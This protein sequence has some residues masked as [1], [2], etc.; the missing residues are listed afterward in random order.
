M[1]LDRVKEEI[2]LSI[3]ARYPIIYLISWEE[4]RV[5]KALLDIARTLKKQIY[6]WSCS[7][8]FEGKLQASGAKVTEPLAALD[9]VASST[10]RAIFV[11][12]DFHPFLENFRVVRKL[13]DSVYILRKSYKTLILLSPVLK[14][15]RELEKDIIVYDVPLPDK[16]ELGLILLKF[17]KEVSSSP[18]VTVRSDTELV[19]RFIN[20]ALG[21]TE[22]EAESVFA[23][24]LVRDRK[25]TMDDLPLIIE[26]KKQIIRKSGFL[27]YF[28]LSET[29]ESVGGLADLKRWLVSRAHAFSEKA[30]EYGLPQPKGLLLLGVQGCGKSL[31][32]KA[33][34]SLWKL[35]LIRL[36]VGSVFN[37]F[38]GASEENMRR[39]IKI[40]ESLAPTVL[41]LDEVEKGFGTRLV[42]VERDGGTAGRVLATFLTW[43][44]EKTR[45]VFVIATCN[46]IDELPAEMLRK[47]RF[48]EIFFIDLPGESERKEIFEIHMKK[49]KRDPRKFD[50][51]GLARISKGFSGAEVEEAVISAMYNAFPE[52]RDVTTKDIVKAIQETVPLSKIMRERI[53]MLRAWAKDRARAASPDSE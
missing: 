49:R 43:L 13:R 15:P 8:A 11:F 44:Q 17:L 45:P 35:P 16:E 3:R 53:D 18:D 1:E 14:M 32:A 25:F 9:K 31:T 37:P 52:N 21:L 48:D 4:A 39:A 30:R 27:E 29:I 20:A 51:A 33:V 12:K 22:T 5:R 36:D 7:E 24:V 26:E 42:G 50:L 34:A 23:K 6:F 19:E 2:A 46:N 40:A 41:W 10:E 47:G 28:D 38:I